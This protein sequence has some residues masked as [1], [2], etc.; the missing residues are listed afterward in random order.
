MAGDEP[1]GQ[2]VLG[3]APGLARWLVIGTVVGL[4]LGVVLW[5]VFDNTSM[6]AA[7]GGL[8]L[9]TGAAISSRANRAGRG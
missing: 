6:I 7:L 9:A 5:L 2:L 1:K 4:A 8:G 3:P